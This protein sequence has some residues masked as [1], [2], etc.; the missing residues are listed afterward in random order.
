MEFQPIATIY[1]D[2]STKFGLPRQS[3]MS[4]HLLSEVVMEPRFSNIEAFRGLEDF[5]YIWLIWVFAPMGK[6][7]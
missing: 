5:D 4:E 3:G 7:E 2:F 1:N 6:R